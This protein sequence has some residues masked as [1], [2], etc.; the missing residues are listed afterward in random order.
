MHIN[1]IYNEDCL[2]TMNKMKDN[3]IDLIITSPPYNLGGDFHT[4]RKNIL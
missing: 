3:F 2:E 4:Y 1:T